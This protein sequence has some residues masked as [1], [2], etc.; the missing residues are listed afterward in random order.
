M[1]SQAKA[2]VVVKVA[3]VVL[4]P[5]VK[6]LLSTRLSRMVEASGYG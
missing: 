6:E 1:S 5:L 4:E 3:E 2:F